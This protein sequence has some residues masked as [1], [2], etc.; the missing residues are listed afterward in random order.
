MSD[1][2]SRAGTWRNW[3]FRPSV[4]WIVAN[5]RRRW[6]GLTAVVVTMLAGV[7][8]TLLKPW[9]LKL[10]VDNVLGGAPLPAPLGA[11]LAAVGVEPGA[12]LLIGAVVAA[13]VAL[14]ALG[15]AVNLGHALARIAFAQRLVYDLSLHLFDHLQRLSLRFHYDRPVGDLIRRVTRDTDFLSHLLQGALLPSATAVFTLI[16]MFMIMWQL[17]PLLSIIAVAI[18]PLMVAAF[19]RYARRMLERSYAQ[20]SAE[21]RIYN[22]VEQSLSALPVVQA[23]S[24]ERRHE[25]ALRSSTSEALRAA[26][27]SADVDVRF[28]IALGFATAIGTAAVMGFGAHQVMQDRLSLG[29]L[30]VF[31]AY[32][33]SFYGPLNSLMSASSVVQTAAGSARR[34]AEI[35]ETEDSVRQAPDAVELRRVAGRITFDG[36]R[37][38]YHPERP[39]LHRVSF[40]VEAG[41]TVAFVGASGA[42]KTTVANL[43]LRMFDPWE[44]RILLDDWDLRQITSSSLHAQMAIV[45]QEPFLFPL[46]VADNIAYGRPSASRADIEAAARAANANAFIERL[47]AGYDTLLGERGATLSGGERQRIAIARALLRDAPILIL[48]EPTSSLDSTTERLVME[49]LERLMAGRTTL[50]IAHRFSTLGAARRIAVL[51][52]GRVVEFDTPGALLER[53]QSLFR[54]L[55]ALQSGT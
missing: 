50:I 9:P 17:N 28:Q 41:E 10:L 47:P 35:L 26:V 27:A 24:Q 4:R 16:G 15:W 25:Q 20:E 3:L 39:V 48:D 55:Y 7:A 29:G 45:L 8:V 40:V 32:Q 19:A 51:D 13:T 30:L 49:A 23:F 31:L 44:G 14:F 46:S 38:G 1:L 11:A 54:R 2:R 52:G 34:V 6:A 5:L 21:G 42:G 53:P 43:L 22:A 36:V 18:V 37:F 33:A 12:R